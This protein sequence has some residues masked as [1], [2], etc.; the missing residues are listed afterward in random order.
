MSAA[1]IGCVIGAVTSGVVSDKF[2]RKWPLLLS[3]FLFT[4][5]SIGTGAASTYLLFIVFRIILFIN[6]II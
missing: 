3:A 6:F 4:F 1:L 2:G 5:S